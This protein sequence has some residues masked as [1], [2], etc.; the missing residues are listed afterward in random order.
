MQQVSVTILGKV[1]K[2]KVERSKESALRRAADLLDT[3]AQEYA[4][5][6]AHQDRQDLL[7]MV[8]LSQITELFLLQDSLTFKDKE[9]IDKLTDIDNALEKHLHPAQNSL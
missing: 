4:K 8:A 7:A 6:F 9:L 5:M 2:L 3:Q 1:Y